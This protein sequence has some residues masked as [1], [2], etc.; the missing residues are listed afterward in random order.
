VLCLAAVGFFYHFTRFQFTTT[1]EEGGER[2]FAFLRSSASSSSEMPFVSSPENLP[3]ASQLVLGQKIDLNTASA[4]DLEAL[5]G[6]GPK[7]AETIVQDRE[8]RGPFRSKEDVMRV[9]GL[10]EKK[11]DQIKAFISVSDTALPKP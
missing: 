3:G 7:M 2:W 6:V 8:K 1:Q 10:K 11:F 5:P 4:K 9:D